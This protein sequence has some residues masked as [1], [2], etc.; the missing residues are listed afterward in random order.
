VFLF[1]VAY[2]AIE[3]GYVYVFVGEGFDIFVFDVYGD[4]PEHDVG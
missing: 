2:G 4:W 3:E 1:A